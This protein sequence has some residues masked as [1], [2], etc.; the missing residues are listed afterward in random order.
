MSLA[1]AFAATF[2]L[3]TSVLRGT[4]W[5]IAPLVFSGLAVVARQM[6]WLT[7]S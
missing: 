1:I 3:E 6:R 2:L 4:D 5:W 7:G